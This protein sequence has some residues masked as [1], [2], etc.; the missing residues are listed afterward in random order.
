VRNRL[1]LMMMSAMLGVLVVCV[2]PILLELDHM[3][4][5]AP[6][7]SH[8][9]DHEHA[10]WILVAVLA[11][12]IM[13]CG[14]AFATAL[15]QRMVE[16][17]LELINSTRLC[18]DG[19]AFLPL[20]PTGIAEIDQLAQM[21]HNSATRVREAMVRERQYSA[22]VSHQ[23]RTPLASLRL[24]LDAAG[25]GCQPELVQPFL[26]DLLHMERTIDHLLQL[27]RASSVLP[28][29]VLLDGVMHRAYERWQPILAKDGRSLVISEAAAVAA[30]GSAIAFD[31]ILDVLISNAHVH[32]RG[33]VVVTIRSLWGGCALDVSDEGDG[34]AAGDEDWIF[35]RG[36]GSGHGIGLSIARA[37][38]ESEGGRLVLVSRKPTTFSLV[39]LAPVDLLLVASG[40]RSLPASS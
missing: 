4:G 2:A 15:A 12:G 9:R 29:M 30:Q 28:D 32:G 5:E 21:F 18:G 40:S 23:L 6:S 24:R 33:S 27:A 35:R 20:A 25:S 19:Q 39:A 31:Q 11:I 36:E 14:F 8:F 3:N 37:L 7:M 13:L 38:T 16:P 22:D 34:L 17:I 10:I 26:N 1:R